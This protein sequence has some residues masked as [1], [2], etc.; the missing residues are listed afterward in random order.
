MLFLILLSCFSIAQNDERKVNDLV[1][2]FSEVLYQNGTETFFYNK[3]YCI[4][5]TVMLPNKDGSMCFSNG[6]YYEVYFFWNDGDKVMMKKIDNCGPYDEVQIEDSRVFDI[7]IDREEQLK[8]EE[9]MR[10]T[11]ENPENVPA[12]S[13]EVHPCRREFNFSYDYKV[14]MKEYELYDLTNESK[15]QNIYYEQ[16]KNVSMVH[17]DSIIDDLIEANQT[18]FIREKK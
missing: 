10:Y 6:T 2:R 18:K 3:R 11:V 17:L 8:N 16:N 15:Y 5:R 13:S 1:D 9:V 12:L 4:G 7:F 14:V